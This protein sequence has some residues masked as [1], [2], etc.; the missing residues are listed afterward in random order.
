MEE[1][2]ASGRGAVEAALRHTPDVA[3]LD[4]AM[5]DG[6]GLWAAARVRSAGFTTRAPMLTMSA[7]TRVC[8]PRCAP[9]PPATR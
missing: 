8:S 9:A 1:V 7:T 2:A 5:P 3:V 4:I 6:D